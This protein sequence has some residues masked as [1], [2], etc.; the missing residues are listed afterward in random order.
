MDAIPGI[1]RTSAEKIVAEIGINME[2]FH[3]A[4]HLCSWAGLVPGLNESAG[5][6]K[7]SHLRKGNVFLKSTLVECAVSALRTKDSFLY[8][9]YMKIAP[10]RGHK[11]A[12]VALAHTM[13]VAIYYMLRDKTPFRD[14]GADFYMQKH[15][16]VLKNRNIR[17]LEKLGFT[18]A[19]TPRA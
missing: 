17:T 15:A 12:V 14:L 4:D 3:S 18:V 9:R 16:D 19:L 8:A 7:P 1:G 2:Q 6:R 5:K 13:L 10:R 11:R